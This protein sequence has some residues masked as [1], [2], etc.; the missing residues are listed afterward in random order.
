[1][2]RTRILFTGVGG[3]G[4]LTATNLLAQLALDC[5]IPVVAGEIHGMAQRGGVVESA[6]LLGGFESPKIVQG[7]ADILLGFEPLETLRSLCSLKRG[8]LIVS[9]IDPIP[10]I[11]V[12]LGREAYPSLS[13]IKSKLESWCGKAHY[14]PCAS[15][16]LQAGS[17]QSAN[18]VLLAALCATNALPFGI[19]ELTTAARKHLKPKLVDLNLRAIE[20][21]SQA[22]HG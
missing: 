10:P 16:A 3:Q 21:G 7:E 14:V 15:L 11:S 4:T 18:M 5:G 8:G 20:L 2:T 17:A 6:V 12:S 9:N 19:N 22:I 1:M 13:E